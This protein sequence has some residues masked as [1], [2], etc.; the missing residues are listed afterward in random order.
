MSEPLAYLMSDA[1]RAFRRELD[2]RA[3]HL[4]VTGLQWRLM[5]LLV[6]QPGMNQGQAAEFLEVEPITLSRMVDRLQDAGMVERRPAPNDRRAWCLHTTSDAAPLIEQL[7][8]IFHDVLDETLDGFS[9]NEITQFQNFV[10]RYREYLSKRQAADDG[11]V[12]QRRAQ[13]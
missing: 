13:V 9:A 2:M 7:R 4:G 10:A 8:A 11:Y 12:E 5:A 6:R 1:S 3:R